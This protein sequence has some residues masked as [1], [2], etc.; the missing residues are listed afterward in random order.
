[1]TDFSIEKVAAHWALKHQSGDITEAEK[2]TFAA[3][4][5]QSDDHRRLFEKSQLILEMTDRVADLSDEDLLDAEFSDAVEATAASPGWMRTA[6]L[7]AASAAFVCVAAVVWLW[8][9]ASDP[10]LLATGKGETSEFAMSDGSKAVL[11]T[12]SRAEIELSSTQRHV[13]LDH[14]EAF[15]D[16]V[17]DPERPFLVSTNNIEIVVVGTKFNVHAAGDSTTVSVISGIVRINTNP[18]RDMKS[19]GSES[20]FVS[21]QAG[22]QLNHDALTGETDIREFNPGHVG[23]WLDGNAIYDGQPLE[24][25]VADLNRYFVRRIELGDAS[26]GDIPV[27][28]TFDLKNAEATIEGLA[29]ALSLKQTQTGSGAIQLSPENQT[30]I[31]APE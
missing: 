26:I 16:V 29:V 5:S 25:V 6:P 14:G 20:D 7:M 19:S 23:A 3:W 17:R 13:T 22:D 21:L 8:I 28:G 2:Q 18:T 24:Y 15:F 31:N 27:S 30:S 11:N 10:I 9:N 1:M 12:A 4:L